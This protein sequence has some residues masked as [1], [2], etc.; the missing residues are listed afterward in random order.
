MI[1]LREITQHDVKLINKWRNDKMLIQTLGSPFRYVNLETE[2]QWFHNYMLHRDTQVRCSICKDVTNEMI[3]VIYL[4]NID[5]VSR[6]AEIAVMIGESEHQNKGYGSLAID[7]IL[8]HAFNNLNL[9]RVTLTVLEDN[10]RA[11]QVY[12]KIGFKQEGLMRDALYKNGKY[13]SLV[14]MS[15]LQREY[16]K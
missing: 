11:L 9:N 2:E 13:V 6:S 5:N 16:K 1:Y 12:R 7:E 8:D 15:I 14:M 4:L 3:G 10:M